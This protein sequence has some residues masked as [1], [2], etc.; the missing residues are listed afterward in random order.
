MFS[1][2]HQTHKKTK[3]DWFSAQSNPAR[4]RLMYFELEDAQALHP[5]QLAS[6]SCLLL[7][8][9][10]F[11]RFLHFL[12]QFIHFCTLAVD[13]RLKLSIC[14]LLR[15]QFSCSIL[16]TG[17]RLHNLDPHIVKKLILPGVLTKHL[18]YN[19]SC[20]LCLFTLCWCSQLVFH[21][22]LSQKQQIWFMISRH[23]QKKHI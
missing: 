16:C 17:S 22:C 19:L 2:I 18:S 5:F 13:N 3:R 1:T 20:R 6:S 14:P 8:G 15:L 9:P 11:F 23:N 12:W 7:P 21:L 4:A 10:C